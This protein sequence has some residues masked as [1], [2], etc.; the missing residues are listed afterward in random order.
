MKVNT[1]LKLGNKETKPI[2]LKS[3]IL[4]QQLNKELLLYDLSRDKVFCLNETSL[5]IWNLCDGKNTV[6]EIRCQVSIQLKTQITEE[7]IWLALD[8]LKKEKLLQNHQEIEINFRC[9]S[10]REAIRKAGLSTMITLPVI[11]AVIAPNAAAAQSQSCSST[12]ACFCN[13][14]SCL[15]LGDVALLQNPCVNTNCSNSGG[16]NCLCVGPFIC[17]VTAG[18]RLGRCGLV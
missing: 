4:M 9:L 5:M 14:A 11:S 18:L 1:N 10:R 2:S 7:F 15:V 16:I 3:N 17:S 6:E 8:K 12:T 13:D